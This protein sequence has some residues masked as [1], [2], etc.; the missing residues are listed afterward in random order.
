MNPARL[1]FPVLTWLQLRAQPGENGPW[2]TARDVAN[3]QDIIAAYDGLAATRLRRVQ[4]SL[5]RM[6]AA[7]FIT[8]KRRG[9]LVKYRVDY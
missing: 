1:D 5:A 3:A 4:E 9:R 8:V 2:F 7:G 6:A